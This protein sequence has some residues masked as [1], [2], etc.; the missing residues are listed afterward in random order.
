MNN[1]G[2]IVGIEDE[3]EGEYT[4]KFRN[5]VRKFGEFVKYERD[6]ASLDF[7][8]HLTSHRRVSHTRLWFQLKG[9]HQET[10]PLSQ[11]SREDYVRIKVRVD[12]L[13]FWFA[14]PEPIY[15][16]V[17]VEC[18]DVFL[19]EDVQEIVHRTWG[20]HF[21]SPDTFRQGQQSVTI[22]VSSNAVLTDDRMNAMRRHQSMRIDGPYFRGRPLG[23]RLDPLRCSLNRLDPND[24]IQIVRR[25]LEFHGYR[26]SSE[27]APIILFDEDSSP[28]ECLLLTEGVLFNT[29]EWVPQLFTEFGY[30]LHS[31][32]RPEGG[33]QYAHGPVA[34]L[35]DGNPHV[36]PVDDKL[37][38]F[39]RRM[40]S[41]NIRQ[42]LVFANTDD[43]SYFGS[44]FGG[45][46]GTRVDCM[47]LLLNDLSYSLLTT[48]MVY[49]EFREVLS[50]NSVWFLA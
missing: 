26:V 42:L 7:G 11:Y 44:F 5:Q 50:W 48:T 41:K 28:N 32:F 46:R 31:D 39:A 47:P 27:L 4:E 18:A 13:K 25:L 37:R 24:Y 21:L 43:Y 30:N 10:L 14:S 33:P 16:A 9:V 15:L 35:I 19:V 20:E 2:P 40:I 1:L 36:F 49:L 29:F 3:F 6:R 38:T 23:H 45:C 22:N 17:Y 34:V 8:L 12:H